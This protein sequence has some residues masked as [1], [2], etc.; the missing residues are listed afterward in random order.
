MTSRGRRYQADWLILGVGIQGP[1]A[2]TLSKCGAHLRKPGLS[3]S[4]KATTSG[5]HV[6]RMD[7]D[8][9]GRIGIKHR[10]E[11]L[12]M[13][14]TCVYCHGACCFESCSPSRAG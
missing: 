7:L 10:G 4:G 2:D 8:S 12:K 13:A 3:T 5:G 9:D 14:E 1:T 6:I 11:G